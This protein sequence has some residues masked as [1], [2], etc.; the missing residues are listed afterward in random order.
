M[1]EV[2][3]PADDERTDRPRSYLPAALIVAGST[4]FVTVIIVSTGRLSPAWLLYL[5][6]VVIASL[7]ADV[8]GGVLA[9]ALAAVALV[10]TAPGDAIA[11]RWA[12]LLTG[13]AVF[14][15]CGAVVGV[16]AHRQRMH[17]H[18]LERVSTHDPLTGLHKAESFGARLAEELRRADRYSTSVGLIA[19]RVEDIE[20]FSRT[21]GR[22][23]ADL[24]LEHLADVIRLGVRDTDIVGRTGPETFAVIIPH[25]D[26]EAIRST[27]ARVAESCASAEFEGDAL[28]PVTRCATS[29]AAVGYPADA[30]DAAALL[31]AVADRLDAAA[32]HA[33]APAATPSGRAAEGAAT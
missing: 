5:I 9:T 15:L 28:E 31:N 26:A 18:A 32:P 12:E 14:L 25:A 23:K 3:A 20:A 7:V 33:G 1:R 17:A 2:T 29:V 8:P 11:E 19:V 30:N 10:L 4:A 21:F 6:P 13:L 16:Q 24:M 27:A 22:Y